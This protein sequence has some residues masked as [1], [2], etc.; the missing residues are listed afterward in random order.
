L[1]SSDKTENEYSLSPTEDLI[2]FWRS[3]V[4]VTVGLSLWWRSIH[5]DV[6]LIVF[7]LQF[8]LFYLFINDHK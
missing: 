5:V 2:R 4:K 3:K 6:H 8:Y 1:N 7:I